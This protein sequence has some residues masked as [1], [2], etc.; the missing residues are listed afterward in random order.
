MNSVLQVLSHTPNIMRYFVDGQY[1]KDKDKY[2]LNCIISEELQT[3]MLN[4]QMGTQKSFSP[5]RF[6]NAAR[7][8]IEILDN[9]EQ[10]DSAHFLIQLLDLIHNE[11]TE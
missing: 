7:E 6:K 8:Y 5:K 10:Q 2:K 4:L 1:D 3:I 11:L 9:N